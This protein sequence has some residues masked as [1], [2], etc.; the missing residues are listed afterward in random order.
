VQSILTHDSDL[1]RYALLKAI[2]AYLQ[3]H[4]YLMLEV[5]TE[6]TLT[7]AEQQLLRFQ[8]FFEVSN[9]RILQ[10]NR[11]TYGGRSTFLHWV[12]T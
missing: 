10:L 5:Q 11:Q 12:M 7:V 9:L 8:E 2:T 4:M 1:V 3:Y 6:T